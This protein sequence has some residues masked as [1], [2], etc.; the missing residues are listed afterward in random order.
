M[1]IKHLVLSGGGPSM[2]QTLGAI[3][4]LE[5]KNIIQR[6]NIKSIYG[7]S[8]GAIVG[9]LYC[10]QFEWEIINDYI[11]KRPWKEVFSINIQHILDAYTKKG[12]FDIK[13]IEKCFNPLLNAKDI[14]L[15]IDL[16]EFYEFSK[17]E[18]HFFS[19]EINRFELVDISY[20]T[21]PNLSLLTAIQM[22]CALPVLLTP[23][24]INEEC[25]IDGGVVCNYPLKYCLE[26]YPKEEEILGLKNHFNPEERNIN[27]KITMESNLLDFIMNFLFKIVINLGSNN[28]P[29]SIPMELT[30]NTKYMSIDYFKKIFASEDARRELFQNGIDAVEDFHIEV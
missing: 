23:V 4:H 10:L 3:Q 22:T 5:K 11:L 20:K 25:F 15:D 29:P 18:L 27:T 13:V 14:K 30:L 24:L 19:F 8:A 17:I 1:T 7:T 12:L 9:V 26:S 6:E 16:K 2:I 28:K 21:H